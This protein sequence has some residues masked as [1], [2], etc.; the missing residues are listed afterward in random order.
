MENGSE[1]ENP[2]IDS[3]NRAKPLQG[4][5][6]FLNKL[7]DILS[8]PKHSH[9]ICWAGDG[10]RFNI[11]N[12][13]A[14]QKE[15]IPVYFKHKNLKSFVRQLN[16][17]GFKK[18]RVG[19]RITE[20]TIDSYRHTLF[21]QNRPELVSQIK[22]KVPKPLCMEEPIPE[23]QTLLEAQDYQLA[24]LQEELELQRVNAVDPSIEKFYTDCTNNRYGKLIL[25]AVQ[26]FHDFKDGTLPSQSKIGKYVS[27]LTSDYI[28]NVNRF[29]QCAAD[30]NKTFTSIPDPHEDEIL[31]KRRTQA[32]IQELQAFKQIYKERRESQASKVHE[33]PP[34]S[35]RPYSKSSDLKGTYSSHPKIHEY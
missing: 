3:E 22:R 6:F 29:I 2:D 17:H 1:N 24:L 7:Y 19:A 31:G 20:S 13:K 33:L 30:P 23:I 10:D 8:N 32:S 9:I 5:Q 15:I 18:I 26:V 4:A 21:R 16:L 34:L 27:H 14:L 11:L 12:P 25:K 35:R 28:H